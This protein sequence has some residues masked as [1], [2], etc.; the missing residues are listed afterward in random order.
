MSMYKIKLIELS[1][2]YIGSQNDSTNLFRLGI[3]DLF[4]HIAEMEL[5]DPNTSQV[6]QIYAH[7]RITKWGMVHLERLYLALAEIY[8]SLNEDET[9]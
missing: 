6:E 4:G 8:K 3:F 1:T 2:P 9:P 7:V 5:S